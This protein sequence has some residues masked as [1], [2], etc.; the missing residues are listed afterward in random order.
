[1]VDP[2]HQF[3]VTPLIPLS[4]NGIDLSFTNASLFMVIASLSV[5]LLLSFSMSRADVL[6]S[7][8][9]TMSEGLYSFI[10]NVALENAGPK[11]LPYLPGII[12]LF[13]F[14]FMGNFLGLMPYSFTFTSQIIVTLSLAL[15]VFFGVTLLG[16]YKHGFHFFSLFLPENTPLAIAPIVVLIEVIS[17]FTRPISLSMRLFANMVAGHMILKVFAGF[18]VAMG[19]FGI[20]PLGFNVLFTAFELLV[21]VLQAYVFTVLTCVYLNDALYL[22]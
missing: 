11:I 7:R 16:L 14:I 1:M 21:A 2:L 20:L 5:I 4:Y 8:L 9:Q 12:T 17:Y 13:M 18:T 3:L 19:V 6:P 10:E 15:I 22:H